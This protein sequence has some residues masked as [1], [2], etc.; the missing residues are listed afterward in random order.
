MIIKSGIDAPRSTSPIERI[1]SI[2][3]YSTVIINRV[4]V[5]TFASAFTA[6]IFLL[7]SSL[8]IGIAG[9]ESVNR[10]VR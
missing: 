10:S 4:V 7:K 3:N 9:R 1:R 2:N 6:D 8:I 5:N